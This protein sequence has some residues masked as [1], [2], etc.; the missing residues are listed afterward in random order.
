MACFCHC[1]CMAIMWL[2]TYVYIAKYSQRII[3]ALIVVSSS[4]LF[5]SSKRL[6]PHHSLCDV[7]L[8]FHIL[9]T[10]RNK[11]LRRTIREKYKR[12]IDF[13]RKLSSVCVFGTS[14]YHFFFLWNYPYKHF[15]CILLGLNPTKAPCSSFMLMCKTSGP[16]KTHL[17]VMSNQRQQIK[18]LQKNSIILTVLA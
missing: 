2:R 7:V 5:T 18:C 17:C 11:D 4:L 16:L 13:S 1:F 8:L 6:Q 10:R 12:K 15:I 3:H 14:F 9:H